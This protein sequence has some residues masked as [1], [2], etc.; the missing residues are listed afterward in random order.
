MPLLGS[1][2]ASTT[3]RKN[4]SISR[5]SRRVLARRNI[6]PARPG[7]SVRTASMTQVRRPIY[8]SSTGRWRAYSRS[9]AGGPEPHKIA[10]TPWKS[11]P[12]SNGLQLTEIKALLAKLVKIYIGFL[13]I[14]TMRE[15]NHPSLTPPRCELCGGRMK[16]VRRVLGSDVQARRALYQCEQ[17]R[18]TMILPAEDEIP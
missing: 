5:H 8:Y 3:A 4:T 1:I 12:K 18:H 9:L 13:N 15:S 6:W 16:L 7:A 10:G 17:C 2:R 11:R 14:E